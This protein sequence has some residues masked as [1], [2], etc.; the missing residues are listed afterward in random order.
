MEAEAEAWE[1]A[2]AEEAEHGPEVLLRAAPAAAAGAGTASTPG[3]LRRGFLQSAHTAAKTARQAERPPAPAATSRA[4]V[5]AAGGAGDAAGGAGGAQAWPPRGWKPLDMRGVP[6]P[7][8]V[9][10]PHPHPNAL[11]T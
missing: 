11:A 3:G 9:V 8:Y 4:L 5:L 6:N 1:A 7:G 10:R 2:V